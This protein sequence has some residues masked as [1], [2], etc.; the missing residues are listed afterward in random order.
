MNRN[1]SACSMK[2]DINSYKKD[3]T[4][5]KTCYNKNENTRKNHIN[6]LIQNQQHT[7]SE[8]KTCSSQHQ[9]KIDNNNPSVSTYETHANV[10]FGP[11]NVAKLDTCSKYLKK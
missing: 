7:P 2:T 3:R 6:T 5:C 9:L 4:A 11:R 8:K 1:C 10:V